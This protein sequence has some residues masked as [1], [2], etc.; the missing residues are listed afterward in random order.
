MRSIHPDIT[1]V[2][3]RPLV[4]SG[5]RADPRDVMVLED[6][7]YI[8]QYPSAARPWRYDER[9]EDVQLVVP[10][11]RLGSV[12]WGG[13]D[14]ERFALDYDGTDGD[15]EAYPASEALSAEAVLLSDWNMDD[16]VSVNELMLAVEVAGAKSSSAVFFLSSVTVGEVA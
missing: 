6:A 15:F 1:A 9:L 8:E 14:P 10:F 11:P 5:L 2:R 13:T 12:N 7:E 4:S 3:H 16:E